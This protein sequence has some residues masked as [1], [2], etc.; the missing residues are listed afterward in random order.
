MGGFF[1]GVWL[2]LGSRERANPPNA[3]ITIA[4]C[5]LKI[6]RS[7]WIVRNIAHHLIRPAP[8]PRALAIHRTVLCKKGSIKNKT[9]RGSRAGE[10]F[11]SREKPTE[12]EHNKNCKQGREAS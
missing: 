8:N 11:Y 9:A 2:Q 3:I 1:V 7:L 6:N 12:S 10:L 5:G 4:R